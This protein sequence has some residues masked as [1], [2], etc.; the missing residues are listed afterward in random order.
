MVVGRWGGAVGWRIGAG[1]A[2]LAVLVGIAGG[3]GVAARPISVGVVDF[4]APGPEADINSVVPSRAAANELTTLLAHAV[5]AEGVAVMS[6]AAMVRAEAG[7]RWQ[8]QDALSFA[9]LAELAQASGTDRLVVG[10]LPIVGSAGGGNEPPQGAKDGNGASLITADVVVQI[11]DADQAR[12]VAETRSAGSALSGPVAALGTLEML[13]D[14]LLPTVPWLMA[15][16]SEASLVAAGM[17]Q[18]FRNPG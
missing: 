11:F 14:A 3:A 1:V 17:G 12:I 18:E 13:R 15:H 16:L 4:Y 10:W 8:K 9:R 6:R 2:I 7:V 5:G